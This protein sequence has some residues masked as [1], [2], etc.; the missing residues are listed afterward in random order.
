LYI[1]HPD[2]SGLRL[3]IEGIFCDMYEHI[4][5]N[6]SPDSLWLAFLT[7]EREVKVVNIYTGETRPLGITQGIPPQW[8][9][10][11]NQLLFCS[12]IDGPGIYTISIKSP[13]PEL[14][15]NFHKGC[16]PAWSSS[17]RFIAVVTQGED[18]GSSLSVMNADGENAH[19]I[20]NRLGIPY[21]A[22]IPDR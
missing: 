21:P 12:D 17:G 11:N 16:I 18:E 22:W 20:D 8:S 7:I 5:P 9:T 13:D 4:A 19:E 10:D 2:G 1:V 6:W 14:L 3:L 15:V